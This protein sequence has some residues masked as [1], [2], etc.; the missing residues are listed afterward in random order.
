L[1]FL[2]STQLQSSR[3]LPSTHLELD[4][5]RK[6]VIFVSCNWYDCVGKAGAV[7]QILSD[8]AWCYAAGAVGRLTTPRAVELG[9]ESIEFRENLIGRGVADLDSKLY[10]DPNTACYTRANIESFLTH[11]LEVSSKD[12][13]EAVYEVIVVEESFL[14]RRLQATIES[15][16]G[17]QP[18]TNLI[19]K[20]A[21]LTMQ[22]VPRTLEQLFALHSSPE[23]VSFMM[24]DEVRRLDE[25]AVRDG[26][27]PP[28][29]TLDEAWGNT[30]TSER[31]SIREAA[32]YLRR[33][34]KVMEV[35]DVFLNGS[36]EE[37]VSI[38]QP[39]MRRQ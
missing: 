31:E 39:R 29:F 21:S 30:Q 2:L 7:A 9:G 6:K 11:L 4:S 18:F 3:V 10:I 34:L 36:R 26:E 22:P 15:M 25:Y 1:D 5:N 20:I 32:Q 24:T 27:R 12:P 33:L 14:V 16:L 8:A 13:S 19:G 23:V 28:H 35:A 17:K 38:F 37:Q